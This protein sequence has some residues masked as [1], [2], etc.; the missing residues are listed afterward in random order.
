MTTW[1]HTL[2]LADVMHEW[3][4]D[5]KSFT[6]VRDEIVKRI[7]EAPF[8]DADDDELAMAVEDL[9]FAETAD[10]FDW[11]WNEFYDWA[12]DHRIWVETMARSD[13]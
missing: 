7:R 4:E 5:L 11:P 13:A 6:E 3:E 10:D 8:F 12:D 1:R 2:E 9:E